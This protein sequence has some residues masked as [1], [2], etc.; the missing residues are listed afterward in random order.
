[1]AKGKLNPTLVF[2]RL[3]MES[4]NSKERLLQTGPS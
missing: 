2:G 3:V 1:M 4:P